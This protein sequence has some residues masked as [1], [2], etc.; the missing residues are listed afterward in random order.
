MRFLPV[1]KLARAV[2]AGLGVAKIIC[3]G[4]EAV[5]VFGRPFDRLAV[6]GLQVDHRAEDS[7][8]HRCLLG[9]DDDVNVAGAHLGRV[10]DQL[11]Q[12]A[13]H[14]RGAGIAAVAF[15]LVHGA[16]DLLHRT[17]APPR[18]DAF[19]PR[20]LQHRVHVHVVGMGAADQRGAV[21]EHRHHARDLARTFD[22]P[23]RA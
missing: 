18:H 23:A 1:L 2:R 11:Q 21:L 17:E 19:E 4:D 9:A 7:G 14:G 20:L 10:R 22:A 12:F 13:L 5:R 8:P 3:G 6:R 15:G 16:G